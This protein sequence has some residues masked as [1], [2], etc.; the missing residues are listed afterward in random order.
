MDMFERETHI[1]LTPVAAD[2]AE[3]FERFLV[4]VVEPAIQARRPDLADRWRLLR[5]V[6]PETADG[7]VLTYAFIF[8]GG[9]V[10]DDWNLSK[11][12]PPHYGDAE[13][14]RLLE[15]WTS[16]FVPYSQ[17]IAALG[18]PEDDITQ[19]GWTF[20]PLNAP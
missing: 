17:W 3:E 8:D 7:G 9:D 4:E 20:E 15:G 10:D 16:T 1:Y 5:P 18:Q 19:T 14:E 6:R 12:L 13:S 11:L 2:Q